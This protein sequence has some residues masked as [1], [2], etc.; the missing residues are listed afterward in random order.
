MRRPDAAHSV[1]WEHHKRE[2][3]LGS[4]SKLIDL[5]VDISLTNTHEMST[6]FSAEANY[7]TP[8]QVSFREP[9]TQKRGWHQQT[10]NEVIRKRE[11]GY[12]AGTS[13]AENIWHHQ[14]RW[15]VH[16][17]RNTV[18]RCPLEVRSSIR[19]EMAAD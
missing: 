18:Y 12:V 15:L 8:H 3:Q 4:R 11:F 9:M 1:T 16:A 13:V 14:L 7:T 6:H 2:I 19:E 10:S 17:C 5:D